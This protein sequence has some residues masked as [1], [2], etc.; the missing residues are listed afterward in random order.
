MKAAD[1][2]LS[3]RYA[4]GYIDLDGSPLT[5]QGETA[6]TARINELQAVRNVISQFRRILLHPLIGYD[7]KNE[8]LARLLPKD[9][10][11]SQAAVF[12]R[13]LI[14]ENRFYLLES[15]IEDCMR[16]YNAYAGI[17]SARAVSRHPLDAEE[18]RRVGG[19][20]SAATGNK[21]HVSHMVSEGVIGGMEIRMGD[22]LIDATVKG[23]LERL[24]SSVLAQ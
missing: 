14:K 21:V 3:K 6:A 12:A 13:L 15:I 2:I 16:F 1:R 9:L 8:V 17:A 11:L 24:K 18:L 20:L 7:E 19:L 22:L 4:R 10:M 23:R 5:K